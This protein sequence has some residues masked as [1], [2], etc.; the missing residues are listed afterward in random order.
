MDD[1]RTIPIQVCKAGCGSF[2]RAKRRY[3]TKTALWGRAAVGVEF[4]FEFDHCPSCGS[5]MTGN[6]KCGAWIFSIVHTHC[7]KCGVPY[8]W[9]ANSSRDRARTLGR[10]WRDI[11]ETIWKTNRQTLWGIEA[12]I[13]TLAVDA[14]VSSDDRH[15]H[16]RTGAAVAIRGACG[17]EVED[18]SKR[19]GPYKLGSAWGT[20]PGRL[21]IKRIIHVAALDSGSKSSLALIG[22]CTKSALGFASENRLRSVALPVMGA[23]TAQLDYDNCVE[24]IAIACIEYFKPA[25]LEMPQ[26]IL[27]VLFSPESFDRSITRA[28]SAGVNPILS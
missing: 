6:C 22:T 2:S 7:P 21:S 14:V 19:N 25:E 13:T 4:R 17:Q 18:E 20:E 28:R 27:L 15:G 9:V 12:D 26:D 5:E 10:N 1:L 8:Q 3:Q 23:G 16:M 24:A 11:G